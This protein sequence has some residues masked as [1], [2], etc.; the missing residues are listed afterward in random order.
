MRSWFNFHIIIFSYAGKRYT[1]DRSSFAVVE[2][3]LAAREFVSLQSQA[4]PARVPVRKNVK[5]FLWE[6]MHTHACTYWR[7]LIT[8]RA[9]TDT[10]K[11]KVLFYSLTPCTHAHTYTC[12][13]AH[14][15]V[16]VNSACC[17]KLKF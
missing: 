15:H 10:H 14:I 13:L 2:R 6:G 7:V 17:R 1:A 11:H 9:I 5:R 8:P 12:T 16:R 4:D 3:I